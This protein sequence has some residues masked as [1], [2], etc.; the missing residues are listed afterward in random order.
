MSKLKQE[1]VL[2]YQDRR[3]S[4]ETVRRHFLD[5]RAENKPPIPKRCDIP[6]C[7]FYSGQLI[8]NGES[9]R[10]IL[11]HI[12]GVHGDN[13]PKNLRFLCPNC[14][15]QQATHGGGNKGK[16]IHNPGGFAHVS[17]DGKKHHTMPLEPGKYTL[18][19]WGNPFKKWKRKRITSA[20]SRTSKSLRALL[21]ADVG[22]YKSNHQF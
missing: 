14:N 5:W 1:E 8:W 22:R 7:Q 10:L 4:Q 6:E 15:S 2:R 21:A 9:L 13:R 19:F 18:G 17:D 16:V 3:R 12:N 11:D 20:C